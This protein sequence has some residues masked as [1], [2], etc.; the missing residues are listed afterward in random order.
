MKIFIVTLFPEMFE[1]FVST[2]MMRKAAENKLVEF[3]IVPLRDFGLGREIKS[4][5]F[6]TA[7]EMEWF[8]AQSQ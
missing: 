2:G 4:M 1:G 8:Y 6:P 7:V 3:D 5:I